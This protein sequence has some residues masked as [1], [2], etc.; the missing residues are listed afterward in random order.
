M[1]TKTYL[2]ALI[3]SGLF[4]AATGM[5]SPLQAQADTTTKKPLSFYGL[6]NDQEIRFSVCTNHPPASFGV[7]VS[8]Q[9]QPQAKIR[10][11]MNSSMQIIAAEKIWGHPAGEQVTRSLTPADLQTLESFLTAARSRGSLPPPALS[12]RPAIAFAR[13][14]YHTIQNG[15]KHADIDRKEFYTPSE[16]AERDFIKNFIGFSEPNSK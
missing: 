10:L 5:T 13:I 1:S 12:G 2:F 9:P 16:E 7:E 15:F 8:T 6:G 14:S 3:A 4:V 11:L